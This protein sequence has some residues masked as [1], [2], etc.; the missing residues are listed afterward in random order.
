MSTV[1]E[2]SGTSQLITENT[3][4][5]DLGLGLPGC[6]LSSYT[7]GAGSLIPWWIIT[8]AVVTLWF[9]LSGLDITPLNCFGQW[10]NATGPGAGC[11]CARRQGD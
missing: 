3:S 7:G 4:L 8:A 9:A 10:R 1:I 11:Q 6:I 5:G 2:N